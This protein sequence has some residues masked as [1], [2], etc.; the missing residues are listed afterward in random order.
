ME[1]PYKQLAEK[2]SVYLQEFFA[3]KFKSAKFH[4][5]EKSNNFSF[6]VINNESN[7]IEF[8]LLS[9]G[10]K[11]L[12]TLVLLLSIAESSDS[13][14]KLIMIDDLLDH[15]DTAR[16]KDCFETLYKISNVQIL[17]AGVQNC[18]HSNAEEFVIEVT[19]E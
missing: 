15:L 2:M 18:T 3:G 12:Y 10:E 13:Q 14:L 19:G 7:Y 16:I 8:D 11:C 5:S 4:L 9:S 1:A 6:G 17:M